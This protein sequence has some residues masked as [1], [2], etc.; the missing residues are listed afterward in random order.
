M[1]EVRKRV[2]IVGDGQCGKTCLLWRMTA[3]AN[4][5]LPLFRPT[6]VGNTLVR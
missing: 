6:I 3:D 5:E 4:E 1:A 2:A